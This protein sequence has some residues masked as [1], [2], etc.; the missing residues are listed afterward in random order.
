[1]R[2]AVIWI[3]LVLLLLGAGIVL[4]RVPYSG[5]PNKRY[6]GFPV[7]TASYVRLGSAAGDV[8]A[9]RRTGRDFQNKLVVVVFSFIAATPLAFSLELVIRMK[10]SKRAQ[11]TS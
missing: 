4:Q 9:E 3:L 5:G 11:A 2:L 7:V 6:T 8:W 10:L 1:M